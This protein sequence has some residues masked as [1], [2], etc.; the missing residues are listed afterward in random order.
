MFVIGEYPFSLRYEVERIEY[1]LNCGLREPCGKTSFACD[2]SE[3]PGIEK[4]H[5]Y[6]Q[7]VVSY[8][9][10]APARFEHQPVIEREI[11]EGTYA[12]GKHEGDY[13]NIEFRA[14]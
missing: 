13:V 7:Q 2:Q 3:Q 6:K 5:D 9:R 1:Y 4:Q 12:S 14:E 11:T 8:D 10:A